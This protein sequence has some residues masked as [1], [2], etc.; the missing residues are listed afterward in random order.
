VSTTEIVIADSLSDTLETG[1][2]ARWWPN[3]LKELKARRA[4]ND[5]LRA[6]NPETDFHQIAKLVVGRV[7][8][9]AFFNDA[10]FTVAYWRQI[11]IRTIAP[12]LHQSGRGKTYET[13]KRVDDTLLFFGFLYRDGWQTRRAGAT[14]D[15]LAAMHERFKIP[16]DDFRYTLSGLCFEPVR[17]PEIL[18]CQVLNEREARALFL[19]WREVGRRWGVDVPEEQA[20]FR[21]WMEHY[22][23]T[24][25]ERTP[26]G[27]Q[28]ATAMGDD[29][30]K[31]FFPGPLKGLGYTVLRCCADDHLLDTVGQPRP[32][33]VSRRIVGLLVR[34]FAAFRRWVPA[35]SAPQLLRQWNREYG[36]ALDPMIVG[37]DWAKKIAPEHRRQA[38]A[39]QCP[40]AAAKATLQGAESDSQ[41]HTPGAPSP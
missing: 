7:F 19:F 24:V 34:A 21:A 37:P 38:K 15:R 8:A 29:F 41:S 31:R 33:R 26:E 9:D 36:T 11:A 5:Q 32:S 27:P 20:A 2:G 13:T 28:L 30:C 16:P 10:L 39:G 4:V 18:G 17:I 25:Y 6:L 40:F 35:S 3:P 22:E 23:D 1:P 14:I 12:V